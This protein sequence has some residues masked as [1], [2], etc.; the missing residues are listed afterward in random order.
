MPRATKP[1]LT[2]ADAANLKLFEE[3]LVVCKTPAELAR[4][5]GYSQTTVYGW[6]DRGRV[7]HYHAPA[8]KKIL[9]APRKRQRG[10]ARSEARVT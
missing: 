5:L 1:R 10:R 3:A 7:P 6:R 2:A 8:L 4:R 9:R